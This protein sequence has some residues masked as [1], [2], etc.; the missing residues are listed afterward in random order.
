LKQIV[1]TRGV[2]LCVESF[3][4]ASHPPVL[5]AGGATS[6][7]DWWRAGFC[8]ALAAEG[9]F[10]IRYDQRDTGRSSFCEPGRP[11]YTGAE[12][13]GD[14]VAVLDGYGI[15]RAHLV[16]QSMG[17]ALAQLVALGSPER[18]ASLTLIDTTRVDEWD[19]SLPGPSPA[20]RAYSE[21]A[22]TP[23]WSD[24]Q[25]IVEHLVAESR[26]LA[27]TR[28]R[29]DEAAVRQLASR[30]LERAASPASLQNH[31][32]LEHAPQPPGSLVD[33]G[34][35][36]LVI[37]GTDDPLF[38]FPH[39][40]ALARAVPGATLVAVEGGGHELHPGDWDQIVDA[41]VAHTRAAPSTTPPERG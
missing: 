37:H 22:G 16:G 28:H 20:Y 33:L 9:R 3:G 12:L 24:P 13:A 19:E 21:A 8:R 4:D 17:G 36:L 26:A 32:L 10:V 30:D 1:H 34:V 41:I 18:V 38:P 2:D 31:A 25:A 5:L 39:G 11:T 6:A 35:P 40:E 23:D 15:G 27:G 14:A 7:M 29:F